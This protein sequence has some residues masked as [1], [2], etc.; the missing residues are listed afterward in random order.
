MK[1]W[2]KT[3]ILSLP[4]AILLT[5]AS[6]FIYHTDREYSHWIAVYETSAIRLEARCAA[7]KASGVCTT[8][9]KRRAFV[10]DLESYRNR[11]MSWWWPAL[12]TMLLA[13]MAVILALA[14]AARAMLHRP[15]NEVHE[16]PKT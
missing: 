9:E 11:I 14:T 5:A 12:V 1:R 10:T 4:V 7:L 2:K 3:L 13:W 8:A 6:R 15:S 16:N